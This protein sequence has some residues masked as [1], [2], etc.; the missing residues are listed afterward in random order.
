MRYECIHH[1]KNTAPCKKRDV[2]SINF[3]AEVGFWG[4]I[5]FGAYFYEFLGLYNRSGFIF[6]KLGGFNLETPHKFLMKK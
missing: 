2:A 6:E 3:G 4:S 1:D 5:H